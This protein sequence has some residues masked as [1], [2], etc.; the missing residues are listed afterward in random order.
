MGINS[1]IAAL[2][3]AALFPAS[4]QQAPAT[5]APSQNSAQTLA[6]AESLLQK[7]QF[8][9]AA[10][11][12]QAVIEK[13]PD[14]PQA[15]FDLG[16]AQSHLGKLPE[17]IAD[18]RKATE[19][20]PKWFEAN[21]NLGLAL[22]RSGDTNDAAAALK[23][24][25][26]LKPSTGGN[27]ALGNAWS[28]LAEV[29]E[30]TQPDEALL[31]YQKAAELD[32]SDSGNLSAMGRLLEARGNAADAE[33]QYLKAANMGNGPAAEQLITLYLQQKRLPDAET[34]LRKYLHQNP[35]S[36][37]AQAQLGKVL[38]AEGKTQEAIA[39]L[40]ASGSN[41][42]AIMRE[43]ASLYMENKQYDQAASL[44]QALVQQNPA[45]ADLHLTLGEALLHRH[46]YPEAEGELIKA[47]QINPKV[48]E[49]YAELAYAASENKHYQLAIR[50]LDLRAK[51]SPENA[52][53]YWL[54]AT[55]YD[56][57]RAVKPAIENYKLF[58][59]ASAG[60]SPDQEFQ[61]RHRIKA[62]QPD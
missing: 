2:L 57:L 46:K 52:G 50:A 58:L 30:H 45:N 44:L 60:K 43:L 55:S 20:S 47:L 4:A 41:A 37:P 1:T 36:G 11:K 7:Q 51:L 29:L 56:N 21:L 40:Q 8:G 27:Q 32:P 15:W 13:H 61:A 59:Q 6:E 48:T 54:R 5:A 10:R 14:N 62:L 9:E 26:T 39:A 16:F 28:A 49:G 35:N 34:W 31:D 22:A 33:Q 19:L 25:V 38:A 12:L 18:Y 17:A 3:L 42:P 23:R 24:S 53:T